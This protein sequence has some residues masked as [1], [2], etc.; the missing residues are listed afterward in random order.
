MNLAGMQWK[1]NNCAKVLKFE[2]VNVVVLEDN[3]LP[4]THAGCLKL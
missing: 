1:R 3:G 2:C 4:R